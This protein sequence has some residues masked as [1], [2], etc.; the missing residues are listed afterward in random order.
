MPAALILVILTATQ[1][2]GVSAAFVD[3]LD[4]PSCK[5]R[6][7]MVRSILESQN[8]EIIRIGC[9]QGTATFEKFSH[10]APPDAPRHAY[11]VTLSGDSVAVES[12]SDVVSCK[13]GSAAATNQKTREQHCVT[14]TQKMLNEERLQQ[15]LMRRACSDSTQA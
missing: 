8:V 15:G 12:V 9:F 5:A 7:E 14:S 1:T 4:T 13:D 10:G 3:S 11:R 2:G 6:G